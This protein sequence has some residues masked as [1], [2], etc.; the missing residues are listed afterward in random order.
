MLR[1]RASNRF[2]VYRRS[3]SSSSSRQQQKF[4]VARAGIPR[5][6]CLFE[7]RKSFGLFLFKFGAHLVVVLVL[8]YVYACFA[9]LVLRGRPFI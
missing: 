3:R 5:C 8:M 9:L 1:L 7:Q 6:L 2:A 4:E